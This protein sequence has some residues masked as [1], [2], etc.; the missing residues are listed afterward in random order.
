MVLDIGISEALE[1]ENTRKA[2][3]LNDNYLLYNIIPNY[4]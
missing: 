4:H 2:I 3:A 1:S